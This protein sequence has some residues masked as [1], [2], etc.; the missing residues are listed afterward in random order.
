MRGKRIAHTRK[1]S[2]FRSHGGRRVRGAIHECEQASATR[3]TGDAHVSG[4][5]IGSRA[6]DTLLTNTAVAVAIKHAAAV[7]HRNL[8][9]VEQVAFVMSA[10]L[11]PDT[12]HI[13]NRIVRRGV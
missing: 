3:L 5:V 10:A 13:L 11:L 8:V 2:R 1:A 6:R 7:I 4:E 9:E 12:G